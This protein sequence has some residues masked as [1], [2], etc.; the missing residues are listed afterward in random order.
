M[1]KVRDRVRN[2]ISYRDWD[3]RRNGLS[4][5]VSVLCQGKGHGMGEG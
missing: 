1:M 4:E 2:R 5:S 3:R